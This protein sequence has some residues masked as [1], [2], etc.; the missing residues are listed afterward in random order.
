MWVTDIVNRFSQFPSLQSLLQITSYSPLSLRKFII[1]VVQSGTVPPIGEIRAALNSTVCLDIELQGHQGL[2]ALKLERLLQDIINSHFARSLIWMACRVV[3]EPSYNDQEREVRTNTFAAEFFAAT[4]LNSSDAVF[5]ELYAEF[6]PNPWNTTWFA[7]PVWYHM[8]QRILHS[9]C[10]NKV[11]GG[12]LLYPKI[13]QKKNVSWE[14]GNNYNLLNV[15]IPLSDVTTAKLEAHYERTGHHILGPCEIRSA[16][17]FNDLKPRYYYSQGGT[18][19]KDS[20]Y[21]KEITVALMDSIPA[22]HVA[23]RRDYTRFLHSEDGE[24]LA[25]WDY[26]NFTSSLSDLRHFLYYFVSGC[27]SLRPDA[28]IRLFDSFL[29]EVY[30]SPW[31]YIDDYNGSVNNLCDFTIFRI[32]DSSLVDFS[33]DEDDYT[34]ANSGPLGVAGNIGSSTANHAAVLTATLHDFDKGVCVGDDAMGLSYEIMALIDQMSKLAPIALSKFGVLDPLPE[35]KIF[36]FLKRGNWRDEQGAF[37]ID[38][39]YDLPLVPYIT[40]DFGN[41]TVYDADLHSRIVSVVTA[42]GSLLW[43][44]YSGNKYQ[45]STPCTD[46]DLRYIISYLRWAY[47]QLD[48]PYKGSMSGNFYVLEERRPLHYSIPP[49]PSYD[50]TLQA[51][52]Y[53]PRQVDWAA[54]LFDSAHTEY[55]IVP[56]EYPDDV[57]INFPYLGETFTTVNSKLWSLLEVFGYV[58]VTK[59]FCVF[60]TYGRE[61][62]RIFTTRTRGIKTEGFGKAVEVCVVKDI[63]EK[64]AFVFE[65]AVPVKPEDL[66]AASHYV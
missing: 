9:F 16:W 31:D 38:H 48:L 44:I 37:T 3:H 50:Q 57:P 27:R 1:T 20:K 28:E 18:A 10:Y 62:R 6:I 46:D 22:S 51:Y 33:A 36:R 39:L 42:A 35:F 29:G 34:M 61:N 25:Y 30:V 19:Y 59:K 49:L 7:D 52:D 12:R 40:G 60:R 15:P 47:K 32:L 11:F 8:A 26:S 13:Q 64:F 21:M 4:T 2:S 14:T 53:D 5:E 41:R 23:R 24:G 55:F 45:R 17:K 43:K 66:L 56:D 54:W 63:P 65:H 58:T